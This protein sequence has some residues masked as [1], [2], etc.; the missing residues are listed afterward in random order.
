MPKFSLPPPNDASNPQNAQTLEKEE[1]TRHFTS[2]SSTYNEMNYVRAGKRG[3]YP[4]IF[5]RHQY[6]LEMLDGLGGR[7]LEVGCGS[8]QL[9]CDLL[10]R[11]FKVVGVDLSPGMI[12]ASRSLVAQ[13]LPDRR[14]DLIMADIEDLCFPNASFDLIIAAGVIEY[15]PSD[16][17]TLRE[18]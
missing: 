14:V 6:I 9:L 3:K 11:N 8:G 5:R 16:Q 18:L 13:R 15:L 12:Q 2:I 4:D 17:R 7:A 1:V 10:R